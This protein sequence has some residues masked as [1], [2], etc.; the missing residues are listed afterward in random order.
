ME[1]NAS[2]S[3]N[4]LPCE[5]YIKDI[6]TKSQD[7]EVHACMPSFLAPLQTKDQDYTTAHVRLIISFA[8]V[9]LTFAMNH[10]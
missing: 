7:I 10:L 2:S 5:R 4:I 8:L 9:T 6:V 1:A 3:Y